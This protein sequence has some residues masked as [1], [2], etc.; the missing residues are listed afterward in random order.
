[1]KPT[2]EK[3]R[4]LCTESSFERALD[5]FNEHRVEDVEQFGNKVTATVSGTYEYMVTIRTDKEDFDA[6]CCPYDWGGY[7]KHII[8]VLLLLSEK[9][10]EVKDK[11]EKIE[12][13]IYSILD[14]V[15]LDELKEFLI[16]EFGNDPDLRN[17]F[18][19]YFS[20]RGEDEGKSIHDYKKEIDFLYRELGDRHG[21]I[22]YGR[23]VNFSHIQD[24][25][26]RYVQ[27]NN[28]LD[29]V[30][31]YQALSEAIA[32]NMDN[33]DDSDGYYGIEF[34]DALENFAKCVN[35]MNLE[36]EDKKKYIKYL[37]DRYIEND[38]DYFRDNYESALKQ[39]C[40]APQ[41]LRY[42]KKMLEQYLPDDL[43]D[44]EKERSGYYNAKELILI[45]FYILDNLDEDRAFYELGEKYYR[46]DYE[47]CLLYARRLEK[48]GKTDRA[49]NVAEE[50]VSLFKDHLTGDLKKF[51]NKF[52]ENT[53]P[54]KYK[55]NLKQLFLQGS[56]WQNNW[57]YY[58]K[59]KGI[60]SEKEWGDLFSEIISSLSDRN[61]VIE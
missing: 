6:D 20:G 15:T 48:D 17:K 32:E 2:I 41:D 33:V 49:V 61:R 10:D 57:E 9:T 24:L 11:K 8:A 59:L 40:T 12:K 28:F 7:C 51:L 39:I 5:Y 22:E 1:M 27:A 13:K 34:D 44:S 52:H 60:C 45:Q 37:F 4:N 21:Y 58:E 46:R 19:I 55:E 18:S 43:Q 26:E 56:F 25:A 14:K 36:H 31:V 3:I 35:L 50:G 42:W 30:K 29:A 23:D 38:P 47:I 16:Y 54:D 53:S